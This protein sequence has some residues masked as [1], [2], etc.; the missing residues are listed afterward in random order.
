MLGEEDPTQPGSFARK[1]KLIRM[2]VLA[3]GS[4]MNFLLAVIAFALAYMSG[5]PTVVHET[6]IQVTTVAADS[7]AQ[8]AGLI[9]G[10]MIMTINGQ[11]SIPLDSFK[12]ITEANRGKPVTLE[13]E[14]GTERRTVTLTPRLNPPRTGR[15]GYRDRADRPSEHSA[16]WNPGI[17]LARPFTGRRSRGDHAV[18]PLP[19][20]PGLDSG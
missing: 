18:D 13:V 14:H 9:P 1:P 8:A 4:F 15:D 3:A 7:P 16:I 6:A 5:V 20:H 12:Q 19:A 2:G 11:P 17:A 10:D